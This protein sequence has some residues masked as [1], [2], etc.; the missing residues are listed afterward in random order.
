MNEETSDRQSDVRREIAKRTTDFLE[1]EFD[2][3]DPCEVI[4][5]VSRALIFGYG[6]ELLRT[7]SLSSI[8]YSSSR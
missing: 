4:D 7:S 8:E 5:G 1:R 3:Y 6:V 2:E